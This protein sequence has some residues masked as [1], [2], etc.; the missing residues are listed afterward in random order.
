MEFRSEANKPAVE[1]DNNANF[2]LK[3]SP[4]DSD[5]RDSYRISSPSEARAN[6]FF[7][8][9]FHGLPRV[10]MRSGGKVFQTDFI[11]RGLKNSFRSFLL[12]SHLTPPRNTSK[13]QPHEAHHSLCGNLY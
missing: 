4:N 3:V 8:C 13:L 10:M 2:Q 1:E 11:E 9:L 12:L 7:F 5:G 6:S